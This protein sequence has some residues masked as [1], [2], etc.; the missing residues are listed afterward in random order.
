MPLIPFLLTATLTALTPPSLAV[1]PTT[2]QP[3]GGCAEAWQAPRSEGAQWCRD[4]GWTVGARYVISPRRIL[5]HYRLPSCEVEDASSGPVPCGW[6]V[7]AVDGNGRG[8]A[9][10]VTG[11]NRHPAFLYVRNRVQP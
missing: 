11:S 5:R 1:L 8:R 10:V 4:H 9:Y 2:A 3:Y 6:N 7:V